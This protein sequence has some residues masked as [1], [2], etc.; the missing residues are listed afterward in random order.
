MAIASVQAYLN[1]TWYT[2]NYNSATGKYEATLTAPGTTSWNQ[3]GN[4]YA[5]KIKATNTAGTVTTVD[6]SDSTVGNALKLR[7]KET[8]KPTILLHHGSALRHK[9][10]TAD[11]LPVTRRSGRVRN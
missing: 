2:L 4:V 11:N 9:Q 3:P 7:V 10:Q 8:V 5:M 6:T 1:G